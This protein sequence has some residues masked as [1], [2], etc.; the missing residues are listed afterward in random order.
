MR[1]E[2]FADEMISSVVADPY[3][4]DIIDREIKAGNPMIVKLFQETLL[5][6]FASVVEF[7][8][9]AQAAGLLRED[10]DPLVTASLLFTCVCDSARKDFMAKKFYNLSFQDQEFRRRYVRQI[11]GLFLNGVMK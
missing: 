2:L 3:G 5:Q 6:A 11:V 1:I 4:F 8:R 7:F 9:Q 10:V